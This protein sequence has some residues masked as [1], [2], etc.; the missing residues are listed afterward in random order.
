MGFLILDSLLLC[1][2]QIFHN[3]KFTYTHFPLCKGKSVKMKSNKHQEKKSLGNKEFTQSWY[4]G[5]KQDQKPD[6]KGLKV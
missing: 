3:K 1:M 4:S 2:F 5:E 6:R